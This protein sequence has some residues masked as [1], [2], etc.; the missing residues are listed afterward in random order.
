MVEIVSI[1]ASKASSSIVKGSALVRDWDTDFVAVEDEVVRAL[2]ANLFVPIPS[3][4]SNVRNLLNRGKWASSVLQVVSFVAGDT[5]SA[6]IKGCALI[7]YWDT[8]IIAVENPVVWALKTD[9]LVPVPWGASNVR[10]LL[11]RGKD[12]FSIYKV[13][14][15]IA[16]NTCS[17]SI[18]SI[19]LVWN[20][21]T[22]SFVIEYPVVWAFQAK[23]I[24]PVPWG[25]SLVSGVIVGKWNAACSFAKIIAIIAACAES[26]ISIPSCTEIINGCAFVVFIKIESI[27]AL[28]ADFKIG[29]PEWASYIWGMGERRLVTVSIWGESISWIASKALSINRIPCLAL[30]TDWHTDSILIEVGSYCTG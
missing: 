2:K 30:R 1:I 20:F 15:L 10:N 11:N 16:T 18:E 6:L 17:T 29:A 21:N 23:V 12:T 14:A 27:W 19:A 28:K 7:R 22:N 3:S 25:A 13:I 4:A 24:F 8:D 9:L 5:G 26:S